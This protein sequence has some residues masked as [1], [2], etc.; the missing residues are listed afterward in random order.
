[1]HYSLTV[2]SQPAAEPLSTLEAKQHLRV[3]HNADDTYIDGLVKAA[4]INAE[5]YLRRSLIN[6]TWVMKM[7][8]FPSVI[9]PPRSPLSSVSSLTYLDTDGTSQTLTVNTDYV[10][11]SSSEPGRI[12]PAYGTSWPS[13]RAIENAVTLTFVAG[14]GTAGSNVPQSIRQALLL[15]VGTWYEQREGVVIGTITAELPMAVESLLASERII[16]A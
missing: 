9:R 16:E 4:R 10:V 15:M 8:C 12:Y 5:T 1:M 6:T 3:D 2:S 14:Y 7:D 11:D 13:T